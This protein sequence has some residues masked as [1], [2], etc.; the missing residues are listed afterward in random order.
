MRST[1]RCA[2]FDA[3][4]RVEQLLAA[5]KAVEIEAPQI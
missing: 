3:V 1:R 5:L 2:S 4:E